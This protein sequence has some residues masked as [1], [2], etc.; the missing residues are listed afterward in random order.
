PSMSSDGRYIAFASNADNLVPGFTTHRNPDIYLD[1][2][3]A[4]VPDLLAP[5]NGQVTNASDSGPGSL[6]QAL[7]DAAASPGSSHTI[8]FTLPA[9]PQTI[10]L[11]T[12][13][14]AVTNPLILAL[15]ASQNVKLQLPP[16]NSWVNS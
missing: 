3:P 13:L 5:P 4:T 14:P 11:L 6:R 9:G 15:D 2:N 1:Y 10:N 16:G 8:S 12:P 7:L